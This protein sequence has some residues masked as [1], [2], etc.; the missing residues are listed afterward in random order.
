MICLLVATVILVLAGCFAE[1]N[2]PM[3]HLLKTCSL[4][5]LLS[6]GIIAGNSKTNFGGFTIFALL[7]VAA[8]FLTTFDLKQHFVSNEE[9]TKSSK[10]AQ[11]NGN[12]LI[13]IAILLSA[14]CL[15]AAGLYIGFTSLFVYLIGIAVG[16]TCTFLILSIKKKLNPFDFMSYLFSFMGVGVLI[17]QIISTLMFSLAVPNLIFVGGLVL[18][19]VYATVRSFSKSKLVELLYFAGMVLVF[20]V[21]IL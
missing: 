20:V 2:S 17:G 1:K 5:S 8:M 19:G 3:F 11:S 15:S 7:S 12:F 21:V 4:A 14:L 18:V 16:F 9:D 6:L 13:S 10:L